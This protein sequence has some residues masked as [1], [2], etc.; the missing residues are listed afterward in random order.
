MATPFAWRGSSLARGQEAGLPGKADD[1]AE[2]ERAATHPWARWATD[3]RLL[4]TLLVLGIL[5]RVFTTNSLAGEPSSDEYFFGLYARDLARAWASG[6]A[7]SLEALTGEG[8]TVALQAAALSFVIPWDVITLGRTLQAF[9]N[10]LCIPLTFLLARQAA[11]PRGAAGAAALL[12]LAVPEFQESAWR[13]WA[14]S[15]ATALALVY[16][17][18]LIRFARQPSAVAGFFALLTLALLYLTKDSAAVTLSP[19]LV[20]GLLAP[21][22]ALVTGWRG[23]A[24]LVTCGALV[25]LAPLALVLG[26]GP[27]VDQLAASGPLGRSVV[28]AQRLVGSVPAALA[29]VPEYVAAL[30]GSPRLSAAELSAGVQWAWAL[31]CVWLLAQLAAAVPSAR[32]APA[33]WLGWLAALIVWLPTGLVPASAFGA[34]SGGDAWVALAAGGLLLGIGTVALRTEDTHRR[35]WSLAFLGLVVVG[36]FTQRLVIWSTPE[37][38]GAFTFRSFMPIVPLISILAGAGIWGMAASVRLLARDARMAHVM[39]TVVVLGGLVSVW[40]PLLRERTTS[41]PLLGRAADRGADR[42]KPDGLRVEAFVAAEQWMQA[43]IRP[44]DIVATTY[45][46]DLAWYADLGVRQF[47]ELNN[48]RAQ[49]QTPQERRPLIMDQVAPDGADYVVDFNVD[50]YRPDS[51]AARQWRM[52]YAWLATRPNVDLLQVQRD[53]FGYPVFYVARN[54]G[55]AYAYGY[56]DREDARAE[57]LAR[58][59]R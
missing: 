38:R 14:D 5:S 19:F 46:R 27:L 6:Q 40:T 58:S 23:R 39:G 29:N 30:A 50:W 33:R 54:H 51:E 32:R 3:R 9:Y 37:L 53:K 25:V 8:R 42:E 17:T 16:L 44:T 26:D 10:A 45:P 18:C 24:V 52:T 11:L 57:Q 31:G 49:A 35:A 20:L 15:Q 47:Y 13:F 36:F 59:R 43:N 21:G 4:L 7:V 48:L 34:E 12:L 2:A 56:R 55:Y 41:R 1:H 22:R 28:V